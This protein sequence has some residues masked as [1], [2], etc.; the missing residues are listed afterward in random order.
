MV[1]HPCVSVIMLNESS[2]GEKN[3]LIFQSRGKITDCDN[4]RL[5]KKF[6][7]GGIALIK[8]AKVP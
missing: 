3:Q 4:D 8:P 5:L 1:E 7:N 6:E 2:R